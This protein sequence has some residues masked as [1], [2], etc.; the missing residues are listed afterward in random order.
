MVEH[1]I[2][3]PRD[4]KTV[5]DFEESSVDERSNYEVEALTLLQKMD[6]L[7]Q[8]TMRAPQF[9]PWNGEPG[10]L[11]AAAEIPTLLPVIVELRKK[12]PDLEFGRVLDRIYAKSCKSRDIGLPIILFR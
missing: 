10:R 1:R 5:R 12:T 11:I 7:R 8:L 3:F 2:L 9:R 4:K 6:F